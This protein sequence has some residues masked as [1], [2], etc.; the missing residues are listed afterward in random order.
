V[1]W[2]SSWP[3]QEWSLVHREARSTIIRGPALARSKA[4]LQIR[5]AGACKQHEFDKEL[6]PWGEQMALVSR[7][8]G[9]AICACTDNPATC[10]FQADSGG[11]I[12]G[13][14]GQMT[15]SAALLVI[16]H[17][18]DE[19]MFFGPALL[20]Q[21]EHYEWHVLC[22]STGVTLLCRSSECPR[23]QH[24]APLGTMLLVGTGCKQIKQRQ[25]CKHTCEC[26]HRFR[27]PFFQL[28]TVRAC[29]LSV[30]SA[31]NA[32]GLGR[33]RSRELHASCEILQVALQYLIVSHEMLGTSA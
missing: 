24:A 12:K 6:D 1:T 5:V 8:W 31:G 9:P 29:G 28:L 3:C 23:T 20:S 25:C 21:L 15:R 2:F 17:P 18:D 22:L 14:D 30:L 7:S 11:D 19:C 32:E 4:Q 10:F 27:L 13:L 16:A 33:V 26:Q